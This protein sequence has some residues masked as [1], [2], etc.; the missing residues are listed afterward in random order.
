VNE[1]K[2]ACLSKSYS[3]CVVV[4][5]YVHWGLEMNLSSTVLAWHIPMQIIKYAHK[6][7]DILSFKNWHFKILIL[8]FIFL[9]LRQGCAM[10]PRLA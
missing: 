1:K 3:T 9:R 5:K 8:L 6:F 4:L 7:F 10:Q 2:K